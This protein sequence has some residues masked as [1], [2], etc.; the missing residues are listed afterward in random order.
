MTEINVKIERHDLPLAKVGNDSWVPLEMLVTHGTQA[1]PTST[2]SLGLLNDVLKGDNLQMQQENF[3]DFAASVVKQMGSFEP[4]V[5]SIS[6]CE[7]V[8]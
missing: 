5:R 7:R 3:A 2:L 4:S 1:L 6:Q 8:D